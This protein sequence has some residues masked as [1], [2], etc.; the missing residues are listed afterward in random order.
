VAVAL[1][2]DRL[3]V[4]LPGPG[5][6]VELHGVGAQAHRAAEVGDLLL[7]GQQVD[8]G[9]LRLD[10]ELRRVGAV[11]PGDVARELGHGDLHAE[12]DP[13]VGHALLAGDLRGEDLALDPAA[14][15]AAGDE[16]AVRAGQA[17]AGLLGGREVL[18][19]TQSTCRRPPCRPAAWRRASVTDL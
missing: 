4:E 11:H 2:D 12:A 8:D 15:E 7:L 9:P 14:A 16:D 13:E 18:E 17:A 1:V 3:A 10:V 6:R 5:V 19:S